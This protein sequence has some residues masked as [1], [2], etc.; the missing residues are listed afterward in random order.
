[1]TFEIAKLT[2][3]AMMLVLISVF[4]WGPEGYMQKIGATFWD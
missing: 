4:I 1:L 3:L 2:I